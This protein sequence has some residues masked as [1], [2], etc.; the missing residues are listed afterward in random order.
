M[1]EAFREKT[2]AKLKADEAKLAN[3]AAH[4]A[5]EVA[6]L[7]AEDEARS[8]K[9]AKCNLEEELR[10]AA[11]Y[12]Q[13][14]EAAAAAAERKRQEELMMRRSAMLKL[15]IQRQIAEDTERKLKEAD[16]RA[17]S[18]LPAKLESAHL[19]SSLRSSP[20]RSPAGLRSVA[21]GATPIASPRP[22]R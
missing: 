20:I 16:E 3:K 6:R 15:Q 9:V 8:H 22:T 2:E 5:A 7:Q 18:E 13:R 12:K 4:L 10:L 21:K 14:E 11:L 1:L 17:R 19:K